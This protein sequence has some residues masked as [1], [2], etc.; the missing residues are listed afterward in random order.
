[1]NHKD[2]KTQRKMHARMFP[3]CLRPPGDTLSLR[4]SPDVFVV[5]VLSFQKLHG[6]REIQCS[7]VDG[8]TGDGA[9]DAVIDMSGTGLHIF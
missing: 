7:F 6:G 1:M 9:P 4:D 8:A 5:K 2:T 3:S